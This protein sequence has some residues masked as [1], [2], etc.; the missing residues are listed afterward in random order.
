MK[1]LIV[2]AVVLT[3]LTGVALAQ[4]PNRFVFG[5]PLP[6]APELAARGPYSVGVQTLELVHPDQID[7]LNGDAT[8][9]RPLTVEVWYPAIIPDGTVQSVVYEDSLGRAD[10]PD[11]LRPFTFEGRALR[12]AAPDNAGG[13]YPL[14]VVSHGYPGSR[15]MMTYLT[16]NLASKGYVVVAIGHTDSTFTDTADFRST[17][18]NRATD[19]IFIIDEMARL[20]ADSTSFL[21]NLVNSENTAIVGYSMGGYGALNVIGAG[22]NGVLGNFVGSSVTPRLATTEGYAADPR[23]KAAVLIAPFGGDLTFAGFPGLSFWDPASLGDINIPTFWIVGSRDDVAIYSGVVGLFDDAINSERY[24][25][26]YQSALHNTGP[27]PPPT[28]ITLS[29]DEYGRYADPVWDE[30]RINNVNQHFITAFL[31]LYLNNNE[32]MSDYLNLAVENSEDGVYTV[33]EAG[34]PTAD[35]TYWKGFPNR[36]ALGLSLRQGQ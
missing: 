23:V 21:S 16:E 17:L 22:Y 25:L 1:Y 24:L 27:N 4:D 13:P 33:D 32:A 26:T 35:Y 3:L 12:D 5:D 7:I 11:S 14:V 18:L 28:D 15:Y 31:G 20:N 8:Y 36:T 10:Q 29:L 9:D 19:Q 6:D 34:N 2:L 30:A